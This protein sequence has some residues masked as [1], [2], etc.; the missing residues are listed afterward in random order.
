MVSQ[1]IT[2][3]KRIVAYSHQ[4]RAWDLPAW[5]LAFIAAVIAADLAVIGLCAVVTRFPGADPPDG[6]GAVARPAHP[7]VPPRVHRRGGGP[8]LRG[9]L[10]GVS[11]DRTGA[12]RG[13][14][15]R[16]GP[17]AGLDPGRGRVRRA[18]VG[19]QQGPGDDRGQGGGP[20]RQRA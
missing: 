2:V 6:P 10:G 15:R 17:G 1:A 3:R 8:V 5:L 11:P 16:P 20:G 14:A 9:G 18:E 7:G 12:G 13:R 4:W 19:G